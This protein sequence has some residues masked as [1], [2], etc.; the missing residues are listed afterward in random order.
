MD[1]GDLI[2]PGSGCRSASELATLM[3][4]LSRMVKAR[5]FYEPGDARLARV[6]ER[7]LRA[8][9]QDLARK[10]ALDLEVRTDSFREYGGRGTLA[11]AKLG[12]LLGDLR[13]RGVARIS[14]AKDL[15]A[16]GVAGFVEAVALRAAELQ[17]RGGFAA[18]VYAHAPLGIV[19]N[20]RPPGSFPEADEDMA[21][22]EE[23][24]EVPQEEL[25]SLAAPSRQPVMA[26]HGAR[27]DPVLEVAQAQRTP[28]LELAPAVEAA[29]LE[30][31]AVDPRGAEIADVLRELE[32][33]EETAQYVDL[34]RQASRLAERAS[35][36][37]NP[38]DYYR[39]VLVLSDHAVGK[40]A[41]R[42]Q[43]LA[44][45]FLSALVQG[46]RLTDLID[47]ACAP[48]GTGSVR[49]SQVLLGLGEEVVGPLLA[50]ADTERDP[51]RRAQMHGVLI[52][53]GEKILGELLRRME[54][55][56]LEALKTAVRLAGETQN[57]DSVPR[58]SQLLAHPDAS[59]REEAAKALVHVGSERAIDA[60][61]RALRSMTAGMSELAVYCLGATGQTRAVA[62]L[63]Q[64]LHDAT[65][66]H[67]VERGR[68][69][70]RAL[71]RIG[72]AEA[73]AALA[74]LLRRKSLIE[75]RWL[76]DLKVAAATALRGLPG[77]DAVGALAQ[78]ARSKDGQLRHAA[79]VALDR[80]AQA[81]ARSSR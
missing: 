30:R 35:S 33:C 72:R 71:G 43:E 31:G 16:E 20:D 12:D 17:S 76:R 79:Q 27:P 77:D 2:E 9:R 25:S 11:H 40:R 14:F 46:P 52:A 64:A 75:R 28:S 5:R 39:V 1:T 66:K 69:I 81:L 53:M 80:R 56:D 73:T 38:E 58:L 23:A 67:Q 45:S 50:A 22:M 18:V 65:E 3:L 44:R 41:E 10:G 4:E 37:G 36:A 6:F 61:I 13:S 49:A 70:I 78:A 29:P 60:L 57:P 15:D 62:P 51:D 21:F 8:W 54:G 32:C 34:A 7:G 59:V 19:V 74:D 42:Q 48:G 68:E 47:R 63:V 24:G 26:S 55:D